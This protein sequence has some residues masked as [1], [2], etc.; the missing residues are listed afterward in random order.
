[1]KKIIIAISILVFIAIVISAYAV[2]LQNKEKYNISAFADDTEGIS[3][4]ADD[5]DAKSEVLSEDYTKKY[6]DISVLVDFNN[7]DAFSEIDDVMKNL[8]KEYFVLYYASL[9]SYDAADMS[10]LFYFDT[11]YERSLTSSMLDYQ[12]RIRRDMDIDLTYNECNVGIDFRSVT[13]TDDGIKVMLY[14]NNYMNYAFAGDTT[15]YTSGIEH[16]FI[17]RQSAGKYYIVS[18]SEIT[19]VYT[20]LTEKFEDLLDRERL[21]LSALTKKQ[22]N[23]LFSELNDIL[24]TSADEGFENLY[25][26]KKAYNENPE[27]FVIALNADNPY[28]SEAALS[29]SYEWA[30]KYEMLRNP[31]YLAYDEYGGNCNNYISQCLFASG[32]PMDLE[33][34]I[35]HQWKWYGDDI[36]GY[37]SAYGRTMSWTGVDFFWQYCSENTGRGLVAECGGNLYSGRPGDI[38][39]Y[40]NE[41]VGVHSVIISK[42]LYD[43]DENILDYLINSNTTDKVDC[44]MSVYGYTDFRL[45][46]IIGWNN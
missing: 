18:H 35:Y 3:F 36:N 29:Y 44:P 21:T 13:E 32:I 14:E 12:I 19:G 45:I 43:E 25:N 16:E 17:I 33:G 1:M 20:L 4:N 38:L 30:G 2:S 11:D 31:L 40:V 22:I 46:R 34:D 27:V 23:K 28:D 15:S 41:G 10:Q 37:S 24:I 42:V 9:G 7:S 26:E 8:L 5:T 6:S 39:Q